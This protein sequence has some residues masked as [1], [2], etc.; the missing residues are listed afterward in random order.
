MDYAH[1]GRSGHAAQGMSVIAAVCPTRRTAVPASPR[2]RSSVPLPAGLIAANHSWP[3]G[4]GG[5]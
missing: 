1:L 5:T 4:D 2:S 3:G